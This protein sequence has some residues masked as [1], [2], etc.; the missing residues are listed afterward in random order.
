VAADYLKRLGFGVDGDSD[1]TVTVPSY[2]P[3]VARP[4][5]LVEEIARIHGYDEIPATLPF[6]RGGVLP[7][8]VRRE[9]A[10]RQMMVG[11]GYFE[12]WN[13]DFM[14]GDHLAW[15]ELPAGLPITSFRPWSCLALRWA[16]PS[17]AW[18]RSMICLRF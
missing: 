2:R 5:D 3:D 14:S 11:S 13:F 1:L 12:V 6:G 7:E 8:W 15:L 10:I 17:L 4:A 18:S 16:S 9:R